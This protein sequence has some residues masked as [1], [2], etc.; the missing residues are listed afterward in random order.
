MCN[1]VD[2]TIFTLRAHHE[3]RLAGKDVVDRCEYFC[4]TVSMDIVKELNSGERARQSA[5]A[6]I[7]K[8]IGELRANEVTY[9]AIADAWEVNPSTVWYIDKGKRGVSNVMAERLLQA[10]GEK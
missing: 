1:G 3:K 10:M 5:L 9:Q 8:R 4:Y 7:R 6:I 2:I